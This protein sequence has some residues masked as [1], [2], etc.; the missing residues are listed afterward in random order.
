MNG[1]C[2]KEEQEGEKAAAK[3]QK[4]NRG[5]KEQQEQEQK[6]G[7]ET[8]TIMVGTSFYITLVGRRGMT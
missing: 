7:G 3:E 5:K 6:P 1:V 4:Q 2:W 8:R